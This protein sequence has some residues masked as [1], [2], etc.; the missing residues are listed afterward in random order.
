MPFVSSLPEETAAP[1]VWALHPPAYA[2]WPDIAGTIMSTDS[3]LSLGEKELVGAYSSAL[4]GCTH[5]F[6]AHYPAAEAFG[7]S[8]ELFANIMQD[9]AEAPV[10]EKTR[11]LLILVKALNDRASIVSQADYDAFKAAGWSEEAASDVIRISGIFEFM[12]TFMIGHGADSSDLSELGPIMAISRTQGKYGHG[13]G[14]ARNK[15]LSILMRSIREFGFIK[16]LKAMRRAKQ[17]GLIG[18]KSN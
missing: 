1:A 12:N 9:P 6:T 17:L 10:D 16:T 3:E 13:E 2:A 11:A 15:P 7:I 8:Q 14:T 4:R 5:C 18:G